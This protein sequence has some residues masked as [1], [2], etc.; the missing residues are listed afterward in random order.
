M[1]IKPLLILIV[2]PLLAGQSASVTPERPIIVLE[3]AMTS[4]YA[5]P[6]SRPTR[7]SFDAVNAETFVASAAGEGA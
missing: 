4:A 1:K 7:Y 3:R 2:S 6:V 5:A